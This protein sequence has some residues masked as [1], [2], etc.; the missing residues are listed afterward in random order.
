MHKKKLRKSIFLATSRQN[1]NNGL[2]QLLGQNCLQSE[3]KYRLFESDLMNLTVDP[4]G[5]TAGLLAVRF[6][7]C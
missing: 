1:K 6:T 3:R 5:V 7:C 2:K 4:F